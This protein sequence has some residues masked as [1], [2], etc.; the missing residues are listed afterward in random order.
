MY[1]PDTSGMD[2]LVVVGAIAEV[3]QSRFTDPNPRSGE[4]FKRSYYFD[5]RLLNGILP[6]DMWLRSKFTP[7]S[8]GWNDFRM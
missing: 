7:V 3:M 4:G 5:E 1:N 6:G 8:G 2:E